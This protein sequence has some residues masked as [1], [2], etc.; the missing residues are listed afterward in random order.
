MIKTRILPALFAAAL[1]LPGAAFAAGEK[2]TIEDVDFSY[3]GP[4]GTFDKYQLQR[5]YQVF[6]EVCAG[7]H[8]MQYLSFRDLGREDGPAIPAEQIKAIAANYQCTDPDLEPGETRDCKASDRFP[9]NVGAGAPDLTLM[10][11]ARVGFSG[12]AGLGINQLFNGIGGPEY[13]YSLLTHY[14]GEEQ[15]VGSSILYG[16]DTMSG[17]WISM[18]QPLYGE[19]I[20]YAVYTESGA[21]AEDANGYTPP[22]PT[23]DQ[24]SQDVAAF[25]MW[26]AEPTMIERKEAGFRNL[27]MIILLAVL[28]YYTNK[29]LW[30]PIKRKSS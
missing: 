30:A 1:A 29:K 16:N 10:A 3:E 22:E 19:D 12:P 20:E 23:L 27:L 21:L 9:A 13:I 25:L 28:L 2:G 6:H 7:C 11:K 24:L 4:F 15:E 18:S 14:N 17:G 26:A 8:G 5:G